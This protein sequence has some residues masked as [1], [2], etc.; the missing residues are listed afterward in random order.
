MQRSPLR[1]EER[2]AKRS[3]CPQKEQEKSSIAR[4]LI[5][6][7]KTRRTTSFRSIGRQ[8]QKARRSMLT[9]AI[10]QQQV[11]FTSM[12][13]A[14]YRKPNVDFPLSR[15][16]SI[17][18]QRNGRSELIVTCVRNMEAKKTPEGV[19]GVFLGRH[20]SLRCGRDSSC[21]RPFTLPL[22]RPF[23]RKRIVLPKACQHGNRDIF[24]HHSGGP[25]PPGPPE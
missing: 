7:H 2:K 11:A 6:M 9:R 8:T 22:T 20:T 23:C 16:L 25:G 3:P 5:A 12:F 14:Q 13:A 4:G 10:N 19:K 21:N 24:A 18:H 17:P 15:T 1:Y